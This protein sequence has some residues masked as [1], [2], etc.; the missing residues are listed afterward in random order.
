MGL[1]RMTVAAEY[2]GYRPY[3][4]LDGIGPYA[5]FSLACTRPPVA[6]DI[7]QLRAGVSREYD[8]SAVLAPPVSTKAV[9]LSAWVTDQWIAALRALLSVLAPPRTRRAAPV[10]ARISK[11]LLAIDSF[12]PGVARAIVSFH[13]AAFDALER[14]SHSTRDLA[15]L[16]DF[17]KIVI[18][19]PQE[20]IRCEAVAQGRHV[21]LLFEHEDDLFDAW[22]QWSSPDASTPMPTP[23]SRAAWG[24]RRR[25][26]FLQLGIPPHTRLVFGPSP[27]GTSRIASELAEDKRLSSDLL[28]NTG[29]RV[30][31]DRLCTRLDDAHEAASKIGYPVV[32]KPVADANRV[33]VITGIS[34]AGMLRRA[35]HRALRQISQGPRALVVQEHMRGAVYRVTVAND[36][37]VFA[38]RAVPL[39][40][41]CDGRSTIAALLRRRLRARYGTY[42]P[43]GDAY[44]RNALFPT[45][46]RPASIPPAGTLVTASLDGNEGGRFVDVTATLRNTDK[47]LFVRAA[48]VLRLPVVGFDVI[49]PVQARLRDATFLDVN[50]APGNSF[51]SDPQLRRAR[52]MA[53]ETLESLFP[54][55]SIDRPFMVLVVAEGRIPAAAAS[56]LRRRNALLIWWRAGYE[57]LSIAGGATSP[58]CV[59]VA[60]TRQCASKLGL[61]HSTYDCLILDGM[62]YSSR[63]AA[64]YG[65]AALLPE[66]PVRVSQ[67]VRAM[68]KKLRRLMRRR[69]SSDSGERTRK[70]EGWN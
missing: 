57:H 65:F 39:R 23:A 36:V 24:A 14:G 60:T 20:L 41:R 58:G 37:V 15:R 4:R 34:D 10:L 46:Y 30:P 19:R 56:E 52:K 43:T 70:E 49:A 53:R 40:L 2:M 11:R 35:W 25:S 42:L 17:I 6:R 47:A 16:A 22:S 44:L 66:R 27:E 21:A 31:R 3:Y 33:G 9:A 51:F 67:E 62:V 63:H 64:P 38:A 18:D 54:K 32:L 5:V 28:R 45:G 8:P 13:S 26:F 1:Q 55:G 68:L 59:V 29:F 7:S 50:A 48:R 12:Y 61:P 69:R